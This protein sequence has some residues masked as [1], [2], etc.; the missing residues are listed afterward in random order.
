[1]WKA[2]SVVASSYRP[3]PEHVGIEGNCR[4]DES[5]PAH[6]WSQVAAFFEA[7]PNAPYIEVSIQGPN[8]CAMTVGGEPNRYY[9][10]VIGDRMG[11]FDLL[12]PDPSDETAKILL[13]GV[14]SD[15]PRRF[16]ATRQL[17]LKAAHYFFAHGELDPELKWHLC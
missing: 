4:V 2:E 9:V 8:R 7:T 6:S 14:I 11:P 15:L 1:M 13:G 5:I 12:G 16:I 3:K 10:S 17:A